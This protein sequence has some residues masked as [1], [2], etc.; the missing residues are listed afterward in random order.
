MNELVVKM[1]EGKYAY[2][3]TVVDEFFKFKEDLEEPQLQPQRLF[4]THCSSCQKVTRFY[5]LPTREEAEVCVRC[6]VRSFSE[7][8]V[9][10]L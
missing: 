2:L 9:D 6:K 4:L 7:L 3:K 1:E 5:E 8:L 10:T